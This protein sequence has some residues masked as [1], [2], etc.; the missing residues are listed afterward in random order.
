MVS[1]LKIKYK[2]KKTVWI[3]SICVS[4]KLW[5]AFAIIKLLRNVWK[6]NTCLETRK[7]FVKA[8]NPLICLEGVVGNAE[9]MREKTTKP[10][11]KILKH[12][13]FDNNYVI[14]YL[15][16]LLKF[17]FQLIYAE[18]RTIWKSISRSLFDF[19]LK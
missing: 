10:L 11:N 17:F 4:N 5:L 19:K 13:L 16:L 6:G 2:N 12:N 8:F 3:Q 14:N 18:M 1:E 9:Y 15:H 7:T